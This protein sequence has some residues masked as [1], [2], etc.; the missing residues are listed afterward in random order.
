MFNFTVTFD[1]YNKGEENNERRKAT[2]H[3]AFKRIQITE[4]KV[5][6]AGRYSMAT[7]VTLPYQLSR[8]KHESLSSGPPRIMPLQYWAESHRHT[9]DEP[10]LKYAS[11]IGLA[12]VIVAS[13]PN[14][15]FYLTLR[16]ASLGPLP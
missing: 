15:A 16:F 14:A 8:S 13:P 10:R 5:R 9:A 11:S 4:V 1:G 7:R 2:I 12:A 3:P 6:A